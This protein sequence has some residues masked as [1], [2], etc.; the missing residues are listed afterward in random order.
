MIPN[1]DSIPQNQPRPN[2]AVSKLDGIAASMEGIIGD[3]VSFFTFIEL[4]F[5]FGSW[6]AC[7]AFVGEQPIESDITPRKNEQ[8]ITTQRLLFFI[9]FLL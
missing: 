1:R 5:T 2:D 7:F 6:F 4:F 3:S 9:S 8:R